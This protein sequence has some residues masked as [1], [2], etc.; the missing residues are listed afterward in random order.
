MRNT[1]WMVGLLAGLGLGCENRAPAPA[2]RP[3]PA[4]LVD[5]EIQVRLLLPDSVDPCLNQSLK[6]LGVAAKRTGEERRWALD[7]RK[8]HAALMPS[9]QVQVEAPSTGNGLQLQTQARWKGPLA[10]LE[11][12]ELEWRLVSL[13][14]RIGAYCD[15]RGLPVEC[16]SGPS[17]ALVACAAGGR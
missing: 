10:G 8:I 13:T 16:L 7:P 11:R 4:P 12:E 6:D 2:A 15:Q 9:G 1:L 3:D 17:G 14:E 5:G